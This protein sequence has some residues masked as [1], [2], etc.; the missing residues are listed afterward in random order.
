MLPIHSSAQTGRQRSDGFPRELAKS[1][2]V[3]SAELSIMRRAVAMP[4]AV[5]ERI[6]MQLQI[7]PR[8][9][10]LLGRRLFLC[11]GAT[12]GSKHGN[13]KER[14]KTDCYMVP[15]S[16]FFEAMTPASHVTLESVYTAPIEGGRGGGRSN[17]HACKRCGPPDPAR[18]RRPLPICGLCFRASLRQA[19]GR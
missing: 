5:R 16:D 2:H 11:R 13:G 1:R 10:Y 7:E 9:T 14:S 18:L 17:R 15:L 8:G 6:V 4:S 3:M 19:R 12:T